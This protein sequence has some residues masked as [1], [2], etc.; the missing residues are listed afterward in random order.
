MYIIDFIKA[1]IN[2]YPKRLKSGFFIIDQKP[3]F[4]ALHQLGQPVLFPMCY[5]LEKFHSCLS[6]GYDRGN[7]GVTLTKVSGGGASIDAES[8]QAIDRRLIKPN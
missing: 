1:I 4:Q 5:P 8:T 7:G 3:K 2:L 6:K